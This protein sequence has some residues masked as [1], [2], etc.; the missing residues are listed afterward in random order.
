MSVSGTIRALVTRAKK[1]PAKV[2]MLA[3]ADLPKES[4]IKRTPGKCDVL[5]EGKSKVCYEV[6]SF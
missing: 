2:E 5:V 3:V 1:A 6:S 4:A